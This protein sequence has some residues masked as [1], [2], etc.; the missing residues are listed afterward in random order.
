MSYIRLVTI[1]KIKFLLRVTLFDKRHIMVGEV[2]FWRSF[3]GT[4]FRILS[5]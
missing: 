3:N 1:L 5:R 4:A 2:N